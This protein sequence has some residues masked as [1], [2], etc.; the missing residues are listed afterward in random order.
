MYK[1]Q[2]NY[3]IELAKKTTNKQANK[4]K[5]HP[6]NFMFIRYSITSKILV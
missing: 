6:S 5:K 3:Q 1:K 4:H 2:E